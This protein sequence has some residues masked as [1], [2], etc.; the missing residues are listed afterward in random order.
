MENLKLKFKIKSSHFISAILIFIFIFY[1][2]PTRAVEPPVDKSGSYTYKFLLYYDNGQL[3]GDRNYEVKYEIASKRYEPETVTLEQSAYRV[4]I[5]NFKDE[6]VK[7]FKFDPQKGDTTFV[8]GKIVVE[9]PYVA[10]GSKASF[11][12]PSNQ[13]LLTIFV[14]DGSFCND[15]GSC[16]ASKGE[17]SQTCPIDCKK[18]IPKKVAKVVTPLNSQNPVEDPTMTIILYSIVILGLGSGAWF[19]WRWWQERSKM[20]LSSGTTNY[21]DNEKNGQ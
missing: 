3:F 8:A 13:H 18:T 11:Y 1:I 5:T 15:D 9:G 19:G 20:I 21:F 7:T 17:D 12:S 16:D 6:V 14:S 4:D 10:D 2:L